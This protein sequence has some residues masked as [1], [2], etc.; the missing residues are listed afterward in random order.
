MTGFRRGPAAEGRCPFC[1]IVA[2]RAPATIVR[3]WPDALA[4]LP[5]RP[6]VEGHTLVISRAHVTDFVVDPVVTA[7]TANRAAELASDYPAGSMN[8][9]TSRGRAAT[10]TV[11][12]LHLHLVPRAERDGLL[13]PWTPGT[14]SDAPGAPNSRPDD[15][16]HP[17]EDHR[18]TGGRTARG[19]TP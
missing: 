2:S 12:H 14:A 5:L 8:L 10:Q 3:E 16:R 18:P 17:E 19:R 9:I 1:E 15:A 7:T 13:L 6:V 4:I 11:F